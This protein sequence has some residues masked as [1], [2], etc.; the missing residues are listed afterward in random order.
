MCALSAL[1]LCASLAELAHGQQ[2]VAISQTGNDNKTTV[3]QNGQGTAV[4]ANIIGSR[5][6][7]IDGTIT[8]DGDGAYAEIHIEGDE[9]NF[10]VAQD[11]ASGFLG[12]VYGS[13]NALSVDQV[14]AYSEAYQNYGAALQAGYGNTA[15]LEQQVEAYGESGGLNQAYINQYGND[16]TALLEQTGTDNL[17]TITQD[18]NGNTGTLIQNGVG[19]SAALNQIGD[20]LPGYTIT[21]DCVATAACNQDITVNQTNAASG[22]LVPSAG[23]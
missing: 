3:T 7:R 16:N 5:N 10:S 17:A 14:N 4:S 9:N 15:T 18:G 1:V 13:G 12:V 22:F 2:D 19:L 21:Q 23:S 8:Q 6:G 11:T 20:N